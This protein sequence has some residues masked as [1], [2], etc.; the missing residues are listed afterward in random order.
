MLPTRVRAIL[1]LCMDLEVSHGAFRLWYYL[2]QHLNVQSGNSFVWPSFLTITN[3][4]GCR[5][6][7][8]AKWLD[9]LQKRKWLK[10]HRRRDREKGGRRKGNR[11]EI[12]DGKGNPIL[13]A[14]P[15]DTTKKRSAK[16][17]YEK[18]QCGTSKKRSESLRKTVAEHNSPFNKGENER[19][20][21]AAPSAGLRASK[22]REAGTGAKRFLKG[23]LDE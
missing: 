6:E 14:K 9:E 16:P 15:N 2:Q 3:D 7:S 22:E 19:N 21:K 8:I 12:L 5:P 1:E 11:Y 13:A 18:A 17:H 20:Q 23:G 4:I 10:V